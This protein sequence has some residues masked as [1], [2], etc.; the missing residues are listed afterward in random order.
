MVC[1]LAQHYSHS[2]T[3]G[4]AGGRA[5]KQTRKRFTFLKTERAAKTKWQKKK[6]V[7]AFAKS[8]KLSKHLRNGDCHRAQMWENGDDSLADLPEAMPNSAVQPGFCSAL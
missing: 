8:R 6:L 7:N 4:V 3:W 5:Y 1:A 2:L